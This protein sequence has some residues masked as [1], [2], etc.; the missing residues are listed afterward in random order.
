MEKSDCDTIGGG[1]I[2]SIFVKRLFEKFEPTNRVETIFLNDSEMV[3]ESI[4]ED[5]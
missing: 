1:F 2:V 3:K 4:L 5:D